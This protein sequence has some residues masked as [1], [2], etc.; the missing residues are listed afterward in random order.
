[1]AGLLAEKGYNGKMIL[2]K[3][4]FRLCIDQKI[5]ELDADKMK[6][7]VEKAEKYLGETIRALGVTHYKDFEVKGDRRESQNGYFERRVMALTLAY[8][9]SYERRGRFTDKL[10]DVIWAIME[11]TTWVIPA[12]LKGNNRL[13]GERYLPS[14]FDHEQVH[15]ICLFSAST[16]ADLALIYH[17]CKDILDDYST[18]IGDRIVFSIR[19]RIT[20]PYILCNFWWDGLSGGKVINWCPWITSNVLLAVGLTEESDYLRE[21]VVDKALKSVDAYSSK[22]ILDDGGCDEGPSYWGA[23]GASYF[24]CLEILYDL[25]GGK[26]DVYSS[27][28]VKKMLPVIDLYKKKEISDEAFR[29]IVEGYLNKVRDR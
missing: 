19:E 24:D 15:G 5:Q 7:I 23:A 22:G 1:M 4:D 16:A 17:L 10:I 2:S 20:K 25:S 27:E 6:P 9:E 11:E 8:A 26:F 13:G 18:V 12:H 3:K 21:S 28:I 29:M 14:T